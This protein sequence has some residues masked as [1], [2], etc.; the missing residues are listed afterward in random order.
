MS[1]SQYC[2]RNKVEQS[3]RGK[4]GNPLTS[5]PLDSVP[6][7]VW[8][9]KSPFSLPLHRLMNCISVRYRTVPVVLVLTCILYCTVLNCFKLRKSIKNKF[10]THRA[11][12][13]GKKNFS[14]VQWCHLGN[15]PSPAKG[16]GVERGCITFEISQAVLWSLYFFVCQ[17]SELQNN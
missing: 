13:V 11:G 15:S 6:S 2:K 10:F 9:K 5:S 4:G 1:F 7:Y 8:E 17:R 16:G 14:F 12:V 3:L